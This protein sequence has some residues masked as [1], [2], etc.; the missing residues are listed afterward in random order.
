LLIAIRQ[1]CQPNELRHDLDAH[2]RIGLVELLIDRTPLSSE[3]ANVDVVAAGEAPLKVGWKPENP[4]SVFPDLVNLQEFG[5]IVHLIGV[6]TACGC[7]QARFPVV[8]RMKS[9]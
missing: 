7:E 2:A 6:H 4:R 1:L 8:R 3:F 5:V 9:T